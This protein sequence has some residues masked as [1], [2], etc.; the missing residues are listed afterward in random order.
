MIASSAATGAA[1]MSRNFPDSNCFT[2]LAFV[3]QGSLAQAGAWYSPSAMQTNPSFLPSFGP[4]T[5]LLSDEALRAEYVSRTVDITAGPEVSLASQQVVSKGDLRFS[6]ELLV[7]PEYYW[8]LFVIPGFLLAISMCC[9]LSLGLSL[10]EVDMMPD[11]RLSCVC[12][13][14]A[15]SQ[16]S[17]MACVCWALL[18][19]PTCVFVP[20]LVA[21]RAAREDS[22]LN[23]AFLGLLGAWLVGSLFF[24]VDF[25]PNRPPWPFRFPF[26]G[27]RP[28]GTE[29]EPTA[30][31]QQAREKQLAA[32]AASTA[33]AS[34]AA[35]E[36][37]RSRAAKVQQTATAD[38]DTS[39]GFGF[40]QSMELVNR[41]GTEGK[42]APPSTS[43]ADSSIPPPP[44]APAFPGLPGMAIPVASASSPAPAST[45]PA[46]APA[47]SV[48]AYPGSIKPSG[49][50]A[51]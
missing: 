20:M 14:W 33:A 18:V 11:N 34:K 16:R 43:A 46:A 19:I 40:V 27:L 42:G 26:M 29:R 50:F 7:I 6:D 17:R 47:P 24:A 5:I 21:V 8:A 32:A 4:S 15:P 23:T 37:S 36:A 1:Q 28:A 3:P 44:P 25:V 13:V 31:E 41:S 45:T 9:A 10:D 2:S 49:G 35:E 12:M 51:L 38:A 48:P 30:A 22:L 39:D